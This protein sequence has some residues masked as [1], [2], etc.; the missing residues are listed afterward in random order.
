MSCTIVPAVIAAV[1]FYSIFLKVG[2]AFHEGGVGPCDGCHVMHS[3]LGGVNKWLLPQTD[4]SSICLNC[5]AGDGSTDSYHIASPDGSAMSPGGDFYWLKKNFF[6]GG[7]SSPG[8]G[9][10]HNVIALDYGFIQDARPTTA[11]GGSYLTSDLGCNSCHDPHGKV[12]SGLPVMGSGS[13]GAIPEAGTTLGNYRLLGSSG[14]DGGEHVKGYVFYNNA[15][16]ARQNSVIPYGETNTS[17][18]DYGSGMSEWCA[19][20]HAGILA[21]EHQGG[22]NGFQHPIGNGAR[23]EDFVASY[24]SYV[25]TGD[26]SGINAT[27]YLALVPFERGATNTVLLDATSTRGPDSASNVMC[28]TCH[29]AH[30]SAFPYAGRWDFTAQLTADS[31]PAMGDNGVTGLDVLY[32]YYGRDMISEFGSGQRILCEKCHDVPKDGYPPGW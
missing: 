2:Y 11:P 32:S 17:H 19:N 22:P 9:H 8:D 20:C 1:L 3:S 29:R 15:P 14:Y 27:S 6:W 16:I 30:A 24:N 31:H 5:H 26:F 25:R 13:Y 4:P 7:G 10:G 12:N 23:L 28:L 21:N 18:V